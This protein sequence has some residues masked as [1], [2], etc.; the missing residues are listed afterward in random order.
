MS[1][2]KHARQKLA[3]TQRALAK[4]AG[5]AY[6]SL[7]LIEK[8]HDTRLSTIEKIG[9]ALHYPDFAKIVNHFFLLPPD[10]ARYVSVKI[11]SGEKWQNPLFNF[12]DEIRRT[13]DQELIESAPIS[14]LDK[15]HRALLASVIETLCDELSMNTP[16]WTRAVETLPTPWFISNVENLKASALLESPIH[17]RKRNI[18]VLCNFLDRA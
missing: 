11:A 12:V 18:F 15:K 17:F 7:Q 5:I 14:T 1:T 13:K 4:R 2:L 3:F 9:Q 6:K 10:S 16:W 8:G